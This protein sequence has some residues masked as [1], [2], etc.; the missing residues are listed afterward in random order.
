[1]RYLKLFEN[2][3]DLKYCL[4]DA[5]NHI[6]EVTEHWD[7]DEV[8]PLK[9]YLFGSRISKTNRENSDLDILF[10]YEGSLRSKYLH[11]PLNEDCVECF[12]IELD[13]VAC[14][15]D[16]DESFIKKFYNDYNVDS[17]PMYDFY[18][19]IYKNCD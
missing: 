12:D 14:N 2:Y 9:A 19:D 1:M 17:L 10:I 4:Y 16:E 15:T 5:V 6:N 3:N 7:V 11:D 8:R 13:I 18:E